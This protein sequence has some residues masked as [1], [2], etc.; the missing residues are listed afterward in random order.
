MGQGET[1]RF[2][3]MENAAEIDLSAI[4]H[5][6]RALTER[7]RVPV[8]AVLK[9]NAYG[10][11]MVEAFR[12]LRNAGADR[13][14]VANFAEA[15]TL[16]ALDEKAFILILGN[17][18]AAHMR[19]CQ[20]AGIA[21]TLFSQEQWGE[22]RKALQ[23]ES[24]LNVHIKV[25]TGFH[26]LGFG[27]RKA[28]VVCIREVV[29]HPAVRVGGIYS[30]LAL[31]DEAS[32]RQ[33]LARFK[34]VLIQLM[35]AGIS[36]EALGVQHLADSISAVEYRWA[37]LDMVRIGAALFGLGV[38]RP[39][40]EGLDLRPAMKLWGR[41]AQVR[42]IGAGDGIGY[43]HAFVADGPMRVATISLG[44]ADGYPRRLSCG[45]GQMLIRGKLAPV[46]GLICMDQLVVDVTEIS[47]ARRGDRA[48]AWD[49]E[50]SSLVSISSV[51]AWAKSNKNEIVAGLAARVPRIYRGL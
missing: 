24:P 46:L 33:Q 18:T 34:S 29:S 28:D 32:D 50:P 10:H 43:D 15:M 49:V 51:A 25:D 16:R 20:A 39:G 1:R 47:Q 48:L 3:E 13:F 36:L 12:T 35:G 5:N 42:E 6:Y 37:R 30:H 21:C 19:E 22:M 38:E 4:A 14:A 45:E 41:I 9:G 44:Y 23:T 17:V 40:Y 2:E 31:L 7:C 27:G 11:G 8:M 26:R